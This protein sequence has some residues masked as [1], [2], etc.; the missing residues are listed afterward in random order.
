M[1]IEGRIEGGNYVVAHEGTLRKIP[2]EEARQD[3]KLLKAIER[4]GWEQIPNG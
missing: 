2:L 3:R 4:N 1:R